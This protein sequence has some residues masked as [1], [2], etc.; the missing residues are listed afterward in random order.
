[1]QVHKKWKEKAWKHLAFKNK[2]YYTGFFPLK[3]QHLLLFF[4]S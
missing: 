3:A 2:M 4:L 1:M